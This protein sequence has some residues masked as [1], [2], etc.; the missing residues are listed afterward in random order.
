MV[1]EL[2]RLVGQKVVLVYFEENK[3]KSIICK[4]LA[5]GQYF[6]TVNFRGRE[7]AISKNHILKIKP[8]VGEVNE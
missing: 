3:E 5:S 8:W 1:N 7:I 6:V 4:L 2:N